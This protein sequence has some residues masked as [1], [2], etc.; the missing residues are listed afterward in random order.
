M[1][2]CLVQVRIAE[3]HDQLVFSVAESERG[4]KFSGM[5][6]VSNPDSVHCMVRI[7]DWNGM[8]FQRS[9]TR[10]RMKYSHITCMV[11]SDIS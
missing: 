6:Y 8:P 3:C 9:S 10:L 11:A 1:L 5:S 2:L 4:S 7:E